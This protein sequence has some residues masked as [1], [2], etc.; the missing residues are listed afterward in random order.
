M[1]DIGF[2][3]S[4][5]QIHPGR[6]LTDVQH[7]EAAG[8]RMA[9]CSDHFAPW[10][11]RQGH[12]GYA[13]SW[14]GAALATTSFPIGVVTAPG[15]RYHPAVVAQKIGTLAAM[16][17]GRFW[18]AL[19][20]GQNLNEHI[21]GGGWPRKELRQQR[22][23]ECVDIIRR[24]LAGEVVNHDGLVT[25][26]RGQL[27][28]LPDVPPRLIGP[29][30]TAGTA[31]QAATWADGLITINQ[32]IADL[33]QLIEA[34]RSAGGDGTLAIQVHLSWA[35]EPTEAFRLAH[36][37]WR[38]NVFPPPVPWDLETPTHFDLVGA[39]VG[40][41]T[42][43]RSVYISDD[44][45]QHAEWLQQLVELGFDQIYLHHVGQD[46]RPF[47]DRFGADVLTQFHNS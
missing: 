20:S 19:G 14:L 7:A 16:F 34:Y 9:M 24:L 36:A 40:P 15:Q 8:F 18:A 1:V 32:P 3:A 23:L 13:W 47:L 5:E 17:P 46:Q 12:S 43:E 28:T 37:Q 11:E 27:W 39:D 25:V 41:E 45:G 10:S 29:A 4:H 22:L 2:H 21:T 38:T 33:Q 30:V 26:D 6:L 31:R 35:P 44:C 42:L